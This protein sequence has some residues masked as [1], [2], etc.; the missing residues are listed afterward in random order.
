MLQSGPG[1]I[2]V[3][4][5]PPFCCKLLAYTHTP[6]FPVCVCARSYITQHW[7]AV[8]GYDVQIR[9]VRDYITVWRGAGF[10]EFT[11]WKGRA[12]AASEALTNFPLSKVS[13]V[14]PEEKILREMKWK[15]VEL[16]IL[17]GTVQHPGKYTYSHFRW[18]WDEKIDTTLVCTLNV[19]LEHETS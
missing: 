10:V 6:S 14:W 4:V 9:T 13:D 12:G 2:T 5:C 3:S 16:K 17:R 15:E 8:L 19:T 11:A 18:E 1:C 7:L